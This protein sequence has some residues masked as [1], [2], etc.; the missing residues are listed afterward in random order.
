MRKVIMF[1]YLDNPKT[2]KLSNSI[3]SFFGHMKGHL[4]MHRGVS[5]NY[6][7]Q[8]LMW[9]L[10]FKKQEVGFISHQLTSNEKDS[11]KKV[12]LITV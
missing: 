10:Y 1:H 5:Y 9:H 11:Q 3:E 7:K 12:L 4:N 2:P 6:R 8:Y